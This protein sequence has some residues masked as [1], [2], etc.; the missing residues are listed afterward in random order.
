MVKSWRKLSILVMKVHTFV[1]KRSKSH[2]IFCVEPSTKPAA[3]INSLNSLFALYQENSIF[4]M[5]Q[6]DVYCCDVVWLTDL[7]QQRHRRLNVR[8]G[9]RSS[10]QKMLG[11]CNQGT[12]SDHKVKDNS[13]KHKIILSQMSL[14]SRI[15]KL[16]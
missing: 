3:Y 4:T 10:L 7:P 16:C 2:S 15:N 6:N 5:G 13:F 9:V 14:C 1:F 12:S 8:A 11:Q